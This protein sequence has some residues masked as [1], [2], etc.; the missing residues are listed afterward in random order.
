MSEE[1]YAVTSE[2]D[3]YHECWDCGHCWKHANDGCEVD[4]FNPRDS[5]ATCPD[6]E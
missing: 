6:C 1:V 2:T 5:L 3:H 4:E